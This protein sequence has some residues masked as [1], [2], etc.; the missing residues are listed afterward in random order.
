MEKV[1][2]VVAQACEPSKRIKRQRQPYLKKKKLMEKF[3]YSVTGEIRKGFM[4]TAS[5]C[6]ASWT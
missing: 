2:G 6:S 3:P 4:S 5:T 1:L